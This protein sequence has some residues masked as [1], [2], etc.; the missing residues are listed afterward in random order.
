MENKMKTQEQFAEEILDQCQN[1]ASVS[2]L[3]TTLE[4]YKSQI[5]PLVRQDIEEMKTQINER[6]NIH[7]KI[8]SKPESTDPQHR[9]GFIDGLQRG[10]SI[11]KDVDS[12]LNN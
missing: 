3:M 9:K 8:L 6:I 4:E 10:L 12:E 1:G 11:I 5:E 2:D 7:E